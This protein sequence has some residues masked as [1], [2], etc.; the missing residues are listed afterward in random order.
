M[1]KTLKNTFCFCGSTKIYEQCCAPF[2]FGLKNAQTAEEL[3]RS[4]Y[5]AYVQKLDQ[6]IQKTWHPS[7]RPVVIENA[8]PHLKWLGLTIVQT[9]S[10]SDTEAYVE[11]VAC[12]RVG[13]GPAQK[14]QE[15]SRFVYEQEQWFY[16]DGSFVE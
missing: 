9:Y 11:F 1:A 14:M 2:H 6:Y 3:M 13:G 15:L 16:I 4:R 8:E 10:C 12:Y 5:S 7:S